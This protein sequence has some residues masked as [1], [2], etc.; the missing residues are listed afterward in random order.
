MHIAFFMQ[1]F[2]IVHALANSTGF[3]G[4]NSADLFCD[5]YLN[6]RRWDWMERCALFRADLQCCNEVHTVKF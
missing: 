4:S 3:N 5:E 6:A 1:Q 2:R